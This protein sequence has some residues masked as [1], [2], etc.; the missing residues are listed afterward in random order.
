[1]LRTTR[2]AAAPIK[3]D[4]T[5]LG[6]EL[7]LENSV[8]YY[9]CNPS[10]LHRTWRTS[11]LLQTTL[12]L[13][14]LLMMFSAEV[15]NSVAHSGISYQHTESKSDITIG[16]KAKQKCSFRLLV[17]NKQ[18]GEITFMYSKVFSHGERAQLE[19]LLA[20]LVYPL[21]N[22][23]QYLS[24][25]QS[26]MTDPLTGKNNRLI[27]N[28]TL[29]HEIGLFHRYKTPLTLLVMD[30]DNFK[31]INDEY[32]HEC[33]DRVIQVIANTLS[34]CVRETDTV[35]RYGGDEF[36]IVLSN[37]S[38]SGAQKI[39]E[40]IRNTLSNLELVYAGKKINVTSSFGCAS[41]TEQD[42]GNSLFTRA[43]EALLL[44][45]KGGRNCARHS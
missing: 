21:R 9:Q 42:V 39:C 29:K 14:S 45:K 8:K 32:G 43:D 28:S 30:V 4:F 24:V 16:R 36:V 27:L 18:L 25:Y 7:S 15:K 1:M 20:S 22:A 2:K 3:L 44:A 37:T 23:L 6:Q 41:L 38:S 17:E 35:V 13:K 33:G 19:F 31:R 40:H 26:S 12:D 34:D 10:Q 11:T 5:S